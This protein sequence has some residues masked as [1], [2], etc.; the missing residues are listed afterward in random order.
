MIGLMLSIPL[1]I[2]FLTGVS[3]LVHNPYHPNPHY[4][5]ADFL[6]ASGYVFRSALYEDLIFRGALLYILIKRLGPQKAVLISAVLFGIYHWF[7][8]GA[9]GQPVQMAIIFLTT[10][11]AGYVFAL[12][13]EKTG[14]IYM[15]FALHFGIDFV[16][17]VIF[18]QDKAIGLQL[19]VKTFA[20][21]PASPGSVISIL[22][23]L[24]HF[25]WFPVLALAY[26]RHRKLKNPL[27]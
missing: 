16:N 13:F 7:S 21:D 23:I 15:P 22:V 2:V 18:S 14:S 20:T 4:T 8:W 17:M 24:V 5:L 6:V 11:L 3:L 27:P 10:G 25:T 12:A 26:L 9:L 19:L 1:Q